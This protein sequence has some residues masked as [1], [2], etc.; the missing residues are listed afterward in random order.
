[1]TFG[2]RLEPAWK[3]GLRR[4]V[5]KRIGWPFRQVICRVKGHQPVEYDC[6]PEQPPGGRFDFSNATVRVFR[7]NR[8]MVKLKETTLEPIKEG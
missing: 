4:W 2:P 5:R 1:M 8:C 6:K 3:Q 7:C